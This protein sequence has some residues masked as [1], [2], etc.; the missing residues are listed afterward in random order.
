MLSRAKK[1]SLDLTGYTST[2]TRLSPQFA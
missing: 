2:F 1:V